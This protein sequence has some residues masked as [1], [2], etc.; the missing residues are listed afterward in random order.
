M[1]L[2]RELKSKI[3]RFA[4]QY[5][6]ATALEEEI[7]SELESL[8]VDYEKDVGVQDAWIDGTQMSNQP[9]SFIKYIEKQ[10]S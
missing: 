4:S 5:A 2:N 7:M 6:K 1:V 10:L 8:G 9:D 3:R